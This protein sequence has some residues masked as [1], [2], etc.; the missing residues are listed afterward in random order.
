MCP[1]SGSASPERPR[2]TRPLPT[3]C[4]AMPYR[5]PSGRNRAA[6]GWPDGPPSW[7]CLG[8]FSDSRPSG[9]EGLTRCGAEGLTGRG[10]DGQPGYCRI[11]RRRAVS[12]WSTSL[13]SIC[14]HVG[15]W[16]RGGSLSLDSKYRRMSAC[17]LRIVDPPVKPRGFPSPHRTTPTGGSSATLSQAHRRLQGGWSWVRTE[18]W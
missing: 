12:R 17:T 13:P 16:A 18:C 5:N 3:S 9:A 15:Q 8:E 11:G 4:K 1:D 14:Q 6:P 2:G 10:A 7:S